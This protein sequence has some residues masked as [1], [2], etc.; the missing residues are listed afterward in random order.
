MQCKHGSTYMYSNKLNTHTQ[1]RINHILTHLWLNVHVLVINHI[2]THLLFMHKVVV[3]C[4]SGCLPEAF[5]ADLRHVIDHHNS[6]GVDNICIEMTCQDTFQVPATNSS[7]QDTFQVP[8]ANCSST[9][10]QDD[11]QSK[12]VQILVQ[13]N[14]QK[15]NC[16]VVIATASQVYTLWASSIRL[17]RGRPTNDGRHCE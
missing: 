15:V 4:T 5:V 12:V 16:L 14:D 9:G 3:E 13:C 17:P 1:A 2:P 11:L 8:A 6:G 10:H 7:H